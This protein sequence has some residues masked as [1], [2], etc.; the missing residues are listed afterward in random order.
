[1]SRNATIR[2][3]AL[4]L[5][6]VLGTVNIM[7]VRTSNRAPDD[8]YISLRYADHL[9]NGYGLRFNPGGER[10]EGFSSPLHVLT[11]AALIRVGFEPRA[12]S[13]VSSISAALICLLTVGIWGGRRYGTLWGFLAALAL[14]LNQCFSFWARSGMETSAF[15]LLVILAMIAAAERRWRAMGMLAGLLAVTRPEGIIYLAP[16]FAHAA[17]IHHLERRSPRDLAVPAILAAGPWVAWFLFR[18][19]YF[20]DVLPNTYYAK[21]DGMSLAQFQ[22]GLDY[23]AGFI[24]LSEIQVLLVMSAIAAAMFLWRGR[25]RPSRDWLGSWQLLVVGLMACTVI[26]ILI[27]GGDWMTQYRFAQPALPVLVLLGGWAGNCLGRSVSSTAGRAAVT[28]VLAL[29]FASQPVR[30]FSHD[31]RHPEHPLDRPLNLVEPWDDST[32]ANLYKLGVE[33]RDIAP[34]GATFALCPVGSFSVAWGGRVIDMLGLNDREIASRPMPSLGEGQ[35]GH[36]K[37]DG[38]LVLSRRPDFILLRNNRNPGT[39]ELAGPDLELNYLMPVIQIWNDAS[40][41]RDYEPFP[42]DIGEDSP[43][44]VY[45]RIGDV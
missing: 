13:Q 36:E 18:V 12:V 17:L 29:V 6:L 42:V 15:A 31:L 35:M 16:L 39:E 20:R 25:T 21:M 44:T 9:A 19:I 1:M 28:A 5:V 11:M 8:S 22:R 23:F 43:F 10:V 24:R 2:G 14:A 30:I 34:P 41:R 26:F 3:V 4:A 38:R 7:V 27:S 45:R 32:T 33:M 37:G 40:F